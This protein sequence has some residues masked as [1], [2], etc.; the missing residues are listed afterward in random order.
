MDTTAQKLAAARAVRESAGGAVTRSHR[1][2]AEVHADQELADAE[3]QR[4]HQ[5]TDDDIAPGDAHGRGKVPL[6]LPVERDVGLLRPQR[7]GT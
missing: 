4:R 1:T 7:L 2:V 3:E 6:A 5:R